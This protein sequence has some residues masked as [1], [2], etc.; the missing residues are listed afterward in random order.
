ME[1]IVKAIAKEEEKLKGVKKKLLLYAKTGSP[2]LRRR[3]LREIKSLVEG[4]ISLNFLENWVN[5]EEV[6]IEQEE[7]EWRANFGAE[8]SRL[9]A[10][11]GISLKGQYPLLRAGFYTIRVSFEAGSAALFW[12]NEAEVIAS[13]LPLSP[14]EIFDTIKK[15]DELLKKR[16]S[17]PRK[18]YENLKIAYKRVPSQ[19][20]G[21][22]LLTEVLREL[23][24]LQQPKAFLENPV[25]KNFVEYPRFVFS[26]DLFLLRKEGLPGIRFVVATFDATTSRR[27]ALWIPDDEEG[28]GTYY[29]YIV[30]EGANG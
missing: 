12:G 5:S 8:L 3:I 7:T 17:E 27:T 19:K 18:F 26:Y 4:G 16:K 23:T 24:F 28:N 15:T 10:G 2:F 20:E 6:K 11:E 13:N 1:E 25:K 21:K 29:S 30:F 22:V 9:L 14:K